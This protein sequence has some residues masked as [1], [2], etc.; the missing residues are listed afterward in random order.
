ME[1]EATGRWSTIKRTT[2]EN[3]AAALLRATR[4]PGGM[5]WSCEQASSCVWCYYGVNL[6][7]FYEI[8]IHYMGINEA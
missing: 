3:T 1:A 2:G 5:P 8:F 6:R 4:R 7:N